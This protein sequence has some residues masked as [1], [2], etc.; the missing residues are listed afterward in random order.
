MALNIKNPEAERLAGEVAALSNES[1]TR[2][3]I[4]ALR[5]RR[6]AL[7]RKR[8]KQTQLNQVRSFLAREVWS[9]KSKRKVI[10][11][12]DLLGYG[13]SGA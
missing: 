13:K 10:S 8:G 9:K 6:D 12:D 2:A 3:V 5:E 7:I 4:E 11:E 1:L